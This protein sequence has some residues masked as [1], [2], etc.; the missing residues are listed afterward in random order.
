MLYKMREYY[1]EKLNRKMSAL[2]GEGKDC[3]QRCD[4][5]NSSSDPEDHFTPNVEA[6][7][8]SGEIVCDECADEI[9]EE[10]SQF[11]LGA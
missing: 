10:C 9:F 11:G 7:E 2:S 4:K 8:L 1:R 3:C 5:H 6:F